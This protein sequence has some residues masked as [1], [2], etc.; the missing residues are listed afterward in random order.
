MRRAT[1]SS[2][3]VVRDR[4]ESS[5]VVVSPCPRRSGATTQWRAGKVTRPRSDRGADG[6]DDVVVVVVVAGE[7][8]GGG[9]GG[10]GGG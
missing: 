8:G 3:M 4:S 2:T 10:G 1:R 5:G 6:E 7:V 9:G